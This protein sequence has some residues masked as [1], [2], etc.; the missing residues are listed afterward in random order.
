MV[1]KTVLNGENVDVE[2]C[3]DIC[4]RRQFDIVE[5][6]R[7]LKNF[8]LKKIQLLNAYLI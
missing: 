2:K 1:V 3:R 6:C 7:K 5:K 8:N 4:L